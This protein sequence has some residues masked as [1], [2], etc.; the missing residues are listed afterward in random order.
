M[1]TTTQQAMEAEPAMPER[2]G[3]VVSG[4]GICLY[5]FSKPWNREGS[6]VWMAHYFEA[7][8]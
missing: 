2:A 3:R 5:I 6:C 7:F 4:V 8:L 1:N